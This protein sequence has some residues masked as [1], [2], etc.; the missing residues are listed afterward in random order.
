[1]NTKKKRKTPREKR[2]IYLGKEEYEAILECDCEMVDHVEN[3]VKESIRWYLKM[4]GSSPY[5]PRVWT[6][7]LQL[8][9]PE[10][11]T[12][13]QYLEGLDDSQKQH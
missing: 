10:G 2:K 5:S 1:M 7:E 13:G 8:G 3:I 12:L 9:L 4:P 6:P 11:M